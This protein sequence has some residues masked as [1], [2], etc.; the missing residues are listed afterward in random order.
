[1]DYAK[2]LAVKAIQDEAKKHDVR[3]QMQMEKVA[4][5]LEVPAEVMAKLRR[6]PLHEG[7]LTKEQDAMCRAVGARMMWAK[8]MELGVV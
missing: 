5:S 4:D 6:G 3:T 1:M 2:A 8:M 7:P